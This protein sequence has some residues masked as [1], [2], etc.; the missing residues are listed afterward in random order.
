MATA[1]EAEKKA[2]NLFTDWHV[3]E[4]TSRRRA[5]DYY[6]KRLLTRLRQAGV[7]LGLIDPPGST[8]AT[9]VSFEARILTNPKDPVNSGWLAL[10]DE[11][12]A[13]RIIRGDTHKE[14]ADAARAMPDQTCMAGLVIARIETTYFKP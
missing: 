6:G 5:R 7:K 10:Q 8:I 12:D 4:Y 13:G 3:D 1:T 14:C 11:D 9:K 2:L